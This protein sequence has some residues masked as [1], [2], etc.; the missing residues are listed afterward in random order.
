MT[1]T[2]TII[3]LFL[4]SIYLNIYHHLDNFIDCTI[5]VRPFAWTLSRVRGRSTSRLSTPPPRSTSSPSA[6]TCASSKIQPSKPSVMQLRQHLQHPLHLP[7][8]WRR[9]RLRQK[10]R[11]HQGSHCLARVIQ[12][13]HQDH[14]RS[15]QI[16]KQG[17]QPLPQQRRITPPIKK[18]PDKGHI[19]LD[20]LKVPAP[21]KY[22]T[23]K[24]DNLKLSRAPT[25]T[26]RRRL[27]VIDRTMSI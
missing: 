17:L 25:F 27:P 23:N 14:L 2:E 12:V 19:A 15:Q 24:Y 1:S 21:N 7:Q 18:I 6:R 16:F 5:C 11:F 20:P 3:T 10:K 9:H 4:F 13:R 8:D 26:M 22:D